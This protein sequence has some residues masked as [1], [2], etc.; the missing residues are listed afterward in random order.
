MIDDPRQRRI[1]A[2]VPAKLGSE[3]KV[4][5]APE[6]SGPAR[7]RFALGMLA[8]VL[9]AL[10]AVPRLSGVAVVSRDPDARRLAAARG[11]LLVD[12]PARGLNGAVA[13]GVAACRGRGADAL[14]IAMGDLPLLAP[15]EI[16]QTLA[17]LPERGAVA[18][19]SLDGTGTNLLALSPPDLLDTHFGPESL[20]LHR[21]AAAERGVVLDEL[22][23]PGAALDVDT[24]ADLARL[25]AVE[26]LS[27]ESR[28]LLDSLG[29]AAPLLRSPPAAARAAVATGPVP[30]SR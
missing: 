18:A 7:S 12:D 25:L 28:R 1:W 19:R 13:A 16:E 23:L 21:A 4:R 22:S 14:V 30:A 10:G 17:H 29:V 26:G 27:L 2:I 8:D 20:A 9:A 3:A 24:P 5:L 15:R 11:A 6:L